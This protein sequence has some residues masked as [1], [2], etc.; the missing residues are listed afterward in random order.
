[1]MKAGALPRVA[2]MLG[3]LIAVAGHCDESSSV[4][5]AGSRF[6][7]LSIHF[8]D[9][10]PGDELMLSLLAQGGW[11][12]GAYM[13]AAAPRMLETFK[14]NCVHATVFFHGHQYGNPVPA[15]G[16]RTPLRVVVAPQKLLYTAKRFSSGT[17]VGGPGSLFVTFR[18]F[19]GNSLEPLAEGN[20]R[21]SFVKVSGA[22]D[23]FARSVVTVMI[24]K[25]LLPLAGGFHTP[26]GQNERSA[27]F[28]WNAEAGRPR[29]QPRQPP[30]NFLTRPDPVVASE[31][32]APRETRPAEGR[33]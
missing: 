2:A 22:A 33:N 13:E 30:S 27:P 17:P 28:D 19:E 18:L 31:C 32:D 5:D 7:D 4:P 10:A 9:P 15:I 14:F 29:E 21:F 16:A 8:A 25:K 20:S 24:E 11:M 3:A 12:G 26:D 6:Q 1:M 23:E